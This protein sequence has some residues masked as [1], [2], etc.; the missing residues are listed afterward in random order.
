MGTSDEEGVK[1]VGGVGGGRHR[2]AP[3]ATFFFIAGSYRSGTTWL[4]DM[5]NA[6]PEAFVLDEGWMLND[7]GHGAEHWVDRGTIARWCDTGHNAWAERI[8]DAE[9]VARVATRGAVEGVMR[10]AAATAH[11]GK[12]V[13]AIGDKTTFYYCDRVDALHRLF[14]DAR[15]VHALRDGRDV[16]VSHCFYL[17]K[18]RSRE[19]PSQFEVL[20][21]G[22]REH[23]ERAYRFHA[24]GEGERVALFCEESLRYFAGVWGACVRGAARAS[25]L[26]KE[27]F[28]EVRYERV[29]ERT[30]EELA[31]VLGFLGLDA[32]DELVTQIVER[33]RF[34]ARTKRERGEADPLAKTRK[35]I[36]GDWRTYFSSEDER[37]WADASGEAKREAGYV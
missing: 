25:S 15:F 10:A 8:G 4:R 6:H 5:L 21:A 34:E 32:R 37:V 1:G 20:P 18:F 14:P 27:R 7:K 26:Y 13:R 11:E 22:A 12:R 28:I 31:R 33:H 29:L 30:A 23:M 19:G 2:V 9:E 36:A 3:D 35:G 24:L 17:F 16:A